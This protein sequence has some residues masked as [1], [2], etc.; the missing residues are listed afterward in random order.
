LIEARLASARTVA[1]EHP[2]AFFARL[3]RHGKR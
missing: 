1:L 2:E 3:N